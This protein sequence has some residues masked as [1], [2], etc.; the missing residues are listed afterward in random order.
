MHKSFF[1]T[2]IGVLFFCFSARAQQDAPFTY[3][4]KNMLFYHPGFSGTEGITQITALYRNQWAGYQPTFDDGG[5]PITQL[6]KCNNTC[7]QVEKRFWC[8][9]R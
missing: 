2:C 4:M 6:T 9:Y 5:A 1:Y 7:L 8:I 3:H